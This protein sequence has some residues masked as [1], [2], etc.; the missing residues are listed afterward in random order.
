[1]ARSIHST[2]KQRLC[3]LK[4]SQSDD[5]PVSEGMTDLEREGLI[6]DIYKLNAERKKQADKQDGSMHVHL[7][8]KGVIAASLVSSVRARKQKRN[9]R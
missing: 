6:K 1:M 8:L 9:K 2:K 5:V 7:K 3:E 4:Y